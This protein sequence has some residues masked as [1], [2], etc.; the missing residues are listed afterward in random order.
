MTMVGRGK[1]EMRIYCRSVAD[2]GSGDS[3][4]DHHCNVYML[5]SSGPIE[6]FSVH[7]HKAGL[8]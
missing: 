4:S 6:P 5:F 3:L 7:K 8:Y 2:R 1:G